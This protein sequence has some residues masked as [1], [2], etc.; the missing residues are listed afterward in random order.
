MIREIT[1]NRS[2]SNSF[3]LYNREENKWLRKRKR[4]LKNPRRK[5][6]RR[7]K[8]RRSKLF[9]HTCLKWRAT[10]EGRPSPFQ[11]TQNPQ[12]RKLKKPASLLN[13]S[14]FSPLIYISA[15]AQK[16]PAAA[17]TKFSPFHLEITGLQRDIYPS[18]I[19]L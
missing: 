2:F 6:S 19:V 15:F 7:K 12:S 3:N 4:K 9:E 1:G 13:N 5:K 10:R 18:R 14:H 16:M 8:A 17:A 11:G